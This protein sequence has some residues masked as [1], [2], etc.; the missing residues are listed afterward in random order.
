MASSHCT[1][2]HSHAGAKLRRGHTAVVD[3]SYIEWTAKILPQTDAQIMFRLTRL[4]GFYI[5]GAQASLP[6]LRV[7][8]IGKLPSGRDCVHELGGAPKDD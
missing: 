2:R 1:F 6:S 4:A 7:C 3:P 5:A 8:L